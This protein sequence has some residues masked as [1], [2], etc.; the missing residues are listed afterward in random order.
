MIIKKG[1]QVKVIAGSHKGQAGKVLQVDRKRQRVQIEN[2]A[3]IKRHIK[4]QR[5]KA[6][7]EGGIV[8][9]FGTIHASNVKLM[10]GESA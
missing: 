4:P 1:D 3:A 2:I 9:D 6:Y 7:P 10:P 8:H 5:N